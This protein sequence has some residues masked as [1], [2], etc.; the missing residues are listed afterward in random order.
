MQNSNTLKAKSSVGIIITWL[1]DFPT[2]YEHRLFSNSSR[3]VN[4]RAEAR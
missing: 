1:I 2:K 3:P 4:N